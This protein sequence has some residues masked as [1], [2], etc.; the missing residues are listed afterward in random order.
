MNPGDSSWFD[1]E[2]NTQVQ[3]ERRG[4]GAGAGHHE[5]EDNVISD[6][7]HGEALFA[8]LLPQNRPARAAFDKLVKSTGKDFAY[9][10]QFM[11]VDPR[12]NIDPKDRQDCYLLSLTLLPEFPQLG[13]RFGRGRTKS[14]N[15]GVDIIIPEGEDVAGLHGRLCWKKGLGGF[16]IDADNARGKDIILNGERLKYTQRVLPFRNQV[17]I[18]EC[19]YSIQFK[20][21]TPVEEER[22]QI[23]LQALFS[24]VFDKPPFM[25]P[26]PSENEQ[27]LG[28]WIV[29]NLIA[30]GAFGRVS[31]VTH[32]ETGQMAAAK[33]IWRTQ[34]NK[35]NVDREVSIAKQLKEWKHEGLGTPFD[36][37]Q[38]EIYDKAELAR[39]SVLL[40]DDWKPRPSDTIS[41]YILFAPLSTSN[42][43]AVIHGNVPQHIYI[44]LFAQ[45]LEAIA[46]MHKNGLSHRDIKP[47]NIVVTT[48]DPPRAQII[49]FGSATFA[50]STLYDSPG[51]VKYLA[52]EQVKGKY[53]GCEVDYW[54]CALVGI[55]LIGYKLHSRIA[56]EKEFGALRESLDS[57]TLKSHLMTSYCK[58]M[59]NYDPGNRLTAE[60]ALQE[61]FSEYLLRDG[62]GKRKKSA[63]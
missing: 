1:T 43:E 31:V 14:P 39:I 8:R 51:T 10:R 20:V 7:S 35:I 21:R 18:G 23:E 46:F 11:Y 36:I 26:T 52:P 13:W 24:R 12:P 22:F 47:Q 55:E 56:T 48:Y 25:L 53:H 57:D 37:S 42:L 2:P 45:I 33:E 62:K 44:P 32:A 50:K 9:H 27:R 17:S 61:Y 41:L 34:R 16:L 59:L 3:E 49:D 29:R 4:A 5:P 6:P 60:A 15:Y 58:K 19:L 28:N 38:R 54:A 63:V 40:N 30:S